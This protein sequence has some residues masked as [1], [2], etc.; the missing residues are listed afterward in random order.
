MGCPSLRPRPVMNT[1]LP[2]EATWPKTLSSVAEKV[3][4]L[5]KVMSK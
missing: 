2:V 4:L 3:E 5:G 1:V